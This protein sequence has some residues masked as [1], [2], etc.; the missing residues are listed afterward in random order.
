[1]AVFNQSP[2]PNLRLFLFMN[3][4]A[5]LL[6]AVINVLSILAPPQSVAQTNDS[7]LTQAIQ[8]QLAAVE[9]IELP[10]E[11]DMLWRKLR[12]FYTQRRYQPVWFDDTGLT[13]RAEIWM[14]TIEAAYTHG[15]DPNDYHIGFFQRHIGDEVVS[16]RVWIELQLTRALLLY[17]KHMQEGR[18]SPKD[19][20]LDW[21]I[22]KPPVNTLKMLQQFLAADDFQKALDSL[23]PAH[24]GYRRLRAAFTKYL[25]LQS[26][27]G[28][29]NI[30][31]GPILRIG[32]SNEQVALIRER[33]HIEGDL[34]IEPVT[35]KRFYDESLK[36]AVEQFQVRYGIDVDGIVG[37]ETRAAMNVP[38]EERIQQMKFNLE[39]WRW[40]PRELGAQYLLVNIAGY[41]LTAYENNQPVFLLR[42]IAGTPE[43]STPAVSGP[44][45]SIIL[46]PY[47]YIPRSIAVND[48]LPLLQHNPNLLKKMEIHVFTNSQKA[49]TEVQGDKI[50]W[51][52]LNEENFPYQLRQDPGP[53][54]SLGS[55]KFKFANDY[56]LYLHDTP[57]K[58]LFYQETR[59]FSS[60]CIR[61]ESAID[62]AKY[63]LKNDNG[64]TKRKIRKIIDSGETVV[65]D[66]KTPVPL[67]LVYW[68]AWVGYDE[69]VYFR[70]DIYGWD[71]SQSAYK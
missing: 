53:A 34:L 71:Q 58:R 31:D 16:L 19:M 1:M 60:G 30:A 49:L 55:I 18:V 64:W 15:L 70:K 47:W 21:H 42:I 56:A 11:M 52:Q 65:L 63:L 4:R 68:T 20:N 7:P 6:I 67:Y 45:E 46:N 29:P 59:A 10:R 38:I 25:A 54:N 22:K 57:K 37:P 35:G 13:A 61:V 5:F 43:R 12:Q 39:R 66:L 28:W 8:E 33:L 41:E 23:P 40:L 14:D 2:T 27:G 9:D 3:T 62:L 36:E 24:D 51:K 69:H 26:A 44:M 32:D 17:I 50:N 48:F